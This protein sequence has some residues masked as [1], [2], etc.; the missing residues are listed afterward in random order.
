MRAGTRIVYSLCDRIAVRARG[1]RQKK[2][3]TRQRISR[4]IKGRSPFGCWYGPLRFVL[5]SR[6]GDS[7]TGALPQRDPQL[8]RLNVRIS[9]A[10][11]PSLLFLF[12]QRAA[13]PRR[14]SCC[15]T[16][17]GQVESLRA[18]FRRSGETNLTPAER[19]GAQL[20]RERERAG[21]TLATIAQRTNVSG[22]YFVA[23]ERGDCSHWPPAVYS[24]A[25]LRGYA[26]TVGLHPEQVVAEAAQYFGNFYNDGQP[27]S[28]RYPE[29]GHELR[30]RLDTP[31][32]NWQRRLRAAGVFA[33]DGGI[34]G[35]LGVCVSLAGGS[36]WIAVAVVLAFCYAVALQRSS[37][38]PRSAFMLPRAGTKVAGVPVAEREEAF[39]EEAQVE[40][41]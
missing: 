33:L 23:L 36:F 5:D 21:I 11:A 7:D 1:G 14:L 9:R 30:L 38:S 10:G 31:V 27:L 15:L 26:K 40:S 19:F 16:I 32:P 24:R 13:V 39:G 17:D 6:P 3:A 35:T 8:V 22:S 34:A 28:T 4:N 25:F 29:T 12:S 20:R 41:V 18:P 37:A 2:L